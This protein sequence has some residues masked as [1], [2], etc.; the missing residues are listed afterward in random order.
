MGPRVVEDPY[1]IL[2]IPDT[3]SPE[4]VRR[5]YA[6]LVRQHPPESDPAGFAQ[7]RRAYEV[8]RD[9]ALR[10]AHDAEAIWGDE[11][12][13]LVQEAQENLHQGRPAQA[14][15]L[16][17]RVLVLNRNLDPAR[18]LLV[19][20]LAAQ[21][22]FR[23]AL[24]EAEHRVSRNQEELDP[25]CHAAW[26]CQKWMEVSRD[27]PIRRRRLEV[28]AH[29]LLDRAHKT[30]P[31][32]PGVRVLRAQLHRLM[33]RP[34][35]ALECLEDSSSNSKGYRVRGLKP[36]LIEAALM[37]ERRDRRGLQHCLFGIRIFC[38]VSG[39]AK[40]AGL[41][42]IHLAWKELERGNFHS[43][44]WLIHAA[45]VSGGGV[46]EVRQAL[47]PLKDLQA[48][49]RERNCIPTS[50][51]GLRRLLGLEIDLIRVPLEREAEFLRHWGEVLNG[52]LEEPPP[53]RRRWA[54]KLR[55]YCPIFSE[56][57]QSLLRALEET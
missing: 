6:R 9:P 44:R 3:A 36:R 33:D 45:E 11:C 26:I 42:F 29:D 57:N 55:E 46:Q 23:E 13:A 17:K 20:S 31:E 1:A 53:I 5:A 24:R 10:E 40:E 48:L 27:H 4:E 35:R 16:L 22:R 2:G 21:G 25:L 8:L 34:E 14:T 41:F 30:A 43:L 37:I 49:I 19:S 50:L 38:L 15:P 51:W 32:H 7:I 12:R 54:G 18:K 52:V 47:A 28:R 39:D 56:R